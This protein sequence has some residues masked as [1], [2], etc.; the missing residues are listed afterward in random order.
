MATREHKLSDGTE[1][2]LYDFGGVDVKGDDGK[3]RSVA[4]T[5]QACADLARLAGLAAD[6]KV[7]DEGVPR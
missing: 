7:D 5:P 4:T 2:A 6:G 1:V 3:W